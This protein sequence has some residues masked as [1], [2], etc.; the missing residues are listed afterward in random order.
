MRDGSLELVATNPGFVGWLVDTDLAVRG[1]IVFLPDGGAEIRV[2]DPAA[3]EY[4]T[5]LAVG[6]EDALATRRR[7]GSPP[8]A[9]AST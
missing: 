2:G 4:R 6:S 7:P 1:G 8:T 3:G 9:T 5:L